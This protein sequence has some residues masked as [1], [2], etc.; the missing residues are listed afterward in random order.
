ML[1]GAGLGSEK[2]YT[3][4]IHLEGQEIMYNIVNIFIKAMYTKKLDMFL[5][6]PRGG[7]DSC[8]LY[9]YKKQPAY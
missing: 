6:K 8:S 9:K 5:E 3:R 1:V 7:S 2:I 4:E